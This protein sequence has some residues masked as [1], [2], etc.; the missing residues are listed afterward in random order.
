MR[1]GSKLQGF[2]VTFFTTPLETRRS[3]G[4]L[5]HDGTK[6]FKNTT[7]FSEKSGSHLLKRLDCWW[8]FIDAFQ[9]Y[10][11]SQQSMYTFLTIKLP[12]SILACKT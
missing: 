10:L 7:I 9:F 5:Q 4:D 8:R 6:K 2:S 1:A 11:E 12:F 3:G